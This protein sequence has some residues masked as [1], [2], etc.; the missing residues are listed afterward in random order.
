M[1][2]GHARPVYYS[3]VVYTAVPGNKALSLHINMLLPTVT[4][5][6][7][8]RLRSCSS[9]VSTHYSRVMSPV[10]RYRRH[11]GSDTVK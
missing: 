9:E 6:S 4:H 5:A 10:G 7:A 3:F 2:P 8:G 1:E 11:A